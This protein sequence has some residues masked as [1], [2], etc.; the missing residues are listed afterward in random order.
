MLQQ[1]ADSEN[2][3]N[4]INN[5]NINFKKGND[6]RREQAKDL[7]TR[8]DSNFHSSAFGYFGY[9]PLH[10]SSQS[11]LVFT[12]FFMGFVGLVVLGFQVLPLFLTNDSTSFQAKVNTPVIKKQAVSRF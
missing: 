7:Y 9:N 4:R 5:E 1:V 11:G 8:Y 12:S 2:I 6:L 10:S 3:I